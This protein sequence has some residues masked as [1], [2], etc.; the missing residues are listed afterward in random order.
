MMNRLGVLVGGW[1]LAVAALAGLP[2]T[3]VRVKPA[4]VAVGTYQR[5]R[6]PAA[7]FR[8]TGFAVVD[9]LHL[10]TNAH[11]LPEKLAA[12]KGEI[13]AVFF[14]AEGRDRLRRAEVVAVDRPHDVA[15]LRIGGKPLPTL[16]L[17]DSERVREGALY[18]F[19]GYPI[20]M[21]LGLYPVTHRGI[22]SSI[23]PIAIPVPRA[24]FLD[25]K[26]LRRLNRP[27]RVFQL[28][29]TAYPG[30][31][32]SPLYDPE[33]GAVVGIINKVFVKESKENLLSKPSGISYAIPIRYAERLLRQVGLR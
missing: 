16:S 25:P 30:N 10:L 7:V 9:G 20:G 17:G 11:V 15:L 1:L 22:V 14:K 29:A 3:V 13:L 21:V 24:G 26:L 5:T 6:A 4:V 12:D 27:Y 18:A 23:T 32:G 33:T 31:S 2:E 28:D 8:G 19:T